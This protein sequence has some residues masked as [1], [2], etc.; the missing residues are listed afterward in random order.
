MELSEF[1][2]WV[3]MHQSSEH[4]FADGCANGGYGFISVKTT[5]SWRDV[6]FKYPEEEVVVPE[7]EGDLYF[8]PNLF[9]EDR[10]RKELM[11]PSR[12]LYADCDTVYPGSSQ[13]PDPTVLWE[14]SPKR[15][16][17][18]WLCP[19]ALK[20][21]EHQIINKRLT[22]MIGADKG[23]WDATQVLRIPGTRNYKYDEQPEVKL[24]WIS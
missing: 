24:V 8:T 19:V 7:V 10:R 17:A 20:P 23:G 2:D 5:D 16:Q 12:W 22:Y 6:S 13:Y 21:R 15:Y 18:M 1:V 3:W 14:T 11:L 9:V 4:G